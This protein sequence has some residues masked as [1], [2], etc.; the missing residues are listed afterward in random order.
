MGKR[1][2]T[3][4]GKS[5]GAGGVNKAAL[6]AGNTCA[7]ARSVPIATYLS[8]DVVTMTDG[9]RTELSSR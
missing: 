1:D 5:F 4:S 3:L 2:R 8:S 6:A 7:G 9:I